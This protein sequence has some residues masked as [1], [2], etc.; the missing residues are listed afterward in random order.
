[1]NQ[2]KSDTQSQQ[3]TSPWAPQASALT[4]A[5][6]NAQSAYGKASD[7]VAPNNFT[8]QMTPEQLATFQ[9]M[10]GYGGNSAIPNAEAAT[11]TGLLNSGA[12]G[13]TGALNTLGAFNPSATNSPAAIA[14]GA[15]TYASGI[16][17]PS[18][19]QAAMRDAT[20]TA[21]DV[22]LPGMESAAAGNGNINGSRTGLAEGLVQ[23]DLANRAADTSATLR[24]NAYNTGAGLTANALGANNEAALAAAT[25]AGALGSNLA[26]SGASMGSNSINDQGNLFTLAGQGG[27]GLQQN[28]QLGLT[29]ELQQYQSKVA[30]PYD[31]LNGLMS[32]IGSNNWG[33][34]SSGTSNTTTTPSAFQTIGGLAFG[35][36]GLMRSDRNSKTDIVRIGALD[37]G[38]PVYRYRY[39]N[40]LDHRVYIGLMA[41]DVEEKTPDAVMSIWGTKHVNYDLA[42][43]HLIRG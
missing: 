39:K 38:T 42:T 35:L 29:N 21:R 9:Q 23:R 26:S 36:G 31:S 11:G 27:A 2:S 15:N 4:S 6:T 13:A 16:D 28:N 5:F 12:S 34:N 17:I 30:S 20:N 25:G 14:A 19:V 37:D 41:Q 33:S 3:T 1:M 32:I 8:A 7:A 18:Q 22:T 24:A 43:R 40:V 10:V